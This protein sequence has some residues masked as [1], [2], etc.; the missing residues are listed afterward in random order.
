MVTF[1]SVLL[2]VIIGIILGITY[3]LS[4]NLTKALPFFNK[5][6]SIFSFGAGI[7]FLRVLFFGI[8]FFYVLR[9][10]SIQIILT[11]VP[12]FILM[13]FTIIKNKALHG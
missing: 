12:F 5:K 1:E 2:S 9:I 11:V 4:F 10:P 3:G 6:S 7:S 8:I 13:W